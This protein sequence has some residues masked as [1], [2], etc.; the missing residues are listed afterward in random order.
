MPEIL[1]FIFHYG[2]HFL[3]PFAIGGLFFRAHWWKAGLI[4]IAANA[5][6][7]DHLLADPVFDPTRCSIGFHPLHTGWAAAIYAAMLAIP[8]WK[9]RALGL[10]LLWHL[11]ID[12]GDC[13]LQIF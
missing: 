2:G 7:M 6:D 5:I 3:V 11:T 9:W 10:G 12:A 13:A 1:P 4:M 8:S